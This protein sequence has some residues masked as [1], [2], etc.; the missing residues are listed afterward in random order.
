M[1]DLDIQSIAPTG[2]GSETDPFRSED[3]TAGIGAALNALSARGGILRLP[4]GRY[5]LTAP[6]EVDT[7]SVC[8]DGGVWAC[9]TD[10]NGVFETAF[11]TKLRLRRT[12]IPAIRAGVQRDPVSGAIV[13]N[14]GVQGDIPGMDTRVL[15]DWEDPRKSAGLCLDAL[16]TDQCAFTKL[17]L[18]GLANGVAA[19]GNAEIDACIFEEINM[20]GCGNGVFFSPYASFYAQFRSCIIADN[21]YY[22]FY[23]CGV[24]H[25]I[26]NME[27]RGTHFVR[28]GGAF[29]DGD[30]HVPAAVFFDHISNCTVT[31]C[32]FDAPGTFWYYDDDATEN[33]QRQ[34]RHRKTVALYVIGNGNRLRDLT[35]IHSS[36]DSIR[37]EGDG[38]VLMGTIAD[39]SIRI[40]GTGNS[41]VNLAFTKPDARLILEGDAK[42]STVL[43]GVEES[44]I[45]RV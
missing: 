4:S 12:D 31:D 29:V 38:N 28:N 27:I 24:G 17:S 5:D 15:V 25:H 40:R 36:S 2:I 45:V 16:R 42:D 23:A 21:P 20:D 33:R 26:H 30:G 44:R 1:T 19:T 7:S 43:I 14:L 9:N 11:G 34:P 37:I 22:G 32:L 8:L 18:C 39:A 3:G 6:V 10:P 41:V 13:R 35:F